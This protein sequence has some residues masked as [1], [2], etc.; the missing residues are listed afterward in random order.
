M[1][2]IFSCICRPPVFCLWENV[3]IQF[4]PF[5]NQFLFCFEL[6]EL[7]LLLK[8]VSSI[9]QSLLN[10]SSLLPDVDIA[11]RAVKPP[12]RVVGLHLQN[13]CIGSSR[14]WLW[15]GSIIV[16]FLFLIFWGVRLNRLKGP[17]FNIFLYSWKPFDSA[18]VSSWGCAGRWKAHFRNWIYVETVTWRV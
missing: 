13:S 2:S 4:C 5:F 16:F 6:Y 15:S 18:R 10:L 8:G 1:V 17:H 3:Y 9:F 11:L 7:Q 12:L 14:A